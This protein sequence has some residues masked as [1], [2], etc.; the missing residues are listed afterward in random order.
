MIGDG[1]CFLSTALLDS[2]SFVIF[3]FFSYTYPKA[4]GGLFFFFCFLF[5]HSLHLLL[6]IDH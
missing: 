5:L 1:D 3:F 2:L 4:M 6:I